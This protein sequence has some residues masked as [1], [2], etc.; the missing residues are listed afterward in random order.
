[1]R[2]TSIL[3]HNLKMGAGSQQNRSV[4]ISSGQGTVARLCSEAGIS[5]FR[6]NHSLRATTATRLYQANVDEQLIME[7][8]GHRS[9]E[10]VREYKR[11][12]D[13]QKA[14]LSDLFNSTTKGSPSMA[15]ALPET[16]HGEIVSNQVQ[17]SQL[18]LQALQLNLP[19]KVTDPMVPH[20]SCYGQN[21]YS[22][23]VFQNIMPQ[24]CSFNFNSCSV[25]INNFNSHS[26]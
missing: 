1:M 16:R 3:Y 7:R 21:T 18:P 5:G 2:F 25:T 10:G 4:T 17:P 11:T 13:D 6:S 14:Q 8:T 24:P 19:T 15:V 9:L 22:Q 20:A 23:S 26:M 12:F